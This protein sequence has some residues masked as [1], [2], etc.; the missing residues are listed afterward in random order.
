[1]PMREFLF[2][3]VKIVFFVPDY[4]CLCKVEV[5]RFVQSVSL[6]SKELLFVV[7]Q[8]SLLSCWT[9]N[10]TNSA[11]VGLTPTI[12]SSVSPVMNAPSP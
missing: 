3:H 11:G 6:R 12:L 1:M 8:L 10:N 7:A 9:S 4:I 5:N 2:I